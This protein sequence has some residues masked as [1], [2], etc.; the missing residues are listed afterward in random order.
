MRTNARLVTCLGL[1]LVSATATAEE[2]KSPLEGQPEIRHRYE[3]RKGRFEIGP[4]FGFSINRALRQA[5]L[6]GAKL[7][8]HLN[9][10]LSFGADF[11]YGI[12]YNS[13]LTNEL[14]NQCDGT[15]VG[16]ASDPSDP[17]KSPTLWEEHT[18]H[19]SDVRLAG[20][21]RAIFTPISGKIG[22]FSKLFFAYDF[23]VFAG[24]GMALMAN[25]YE[26]ESDIDNV[27]QGFR[28]GPAWGFGMHMFF[29]KYF[30]TGLEIR[31]IAFSDNESGGDI[32]R[33]L[34]DTE[35]NEKRIKIDKDD[36][37]FSNHWFVG[38]N[39][40]FFLPTTVEITP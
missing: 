9:D 7:E 38:I 24:L 22:L 35:L 3:M 37:Q 17:A 21:I 31:D 33:G 12:S 19:F 23:Y 8:Y 18:K 40:T 27:S 39:F 32:T 26:G 29:T 10:W 30:S 13:G 20:D 34:T 4:S 11:A 6:V 16:P 15:C 5:I 36:K 25:K 1:V 2:R 28:V 14:K